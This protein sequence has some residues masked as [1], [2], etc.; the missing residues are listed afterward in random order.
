VKKGGKAPHI[1]IYA[2][3][4]DTNS[5]R[6]KPSG[7]GETLS[8]GKKILWINNFVGNDGEAKV[9]AFKQNQKCT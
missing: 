2:Q 8:V 5:G 4:V 1:N 6:F 9:A 7:H 3:K